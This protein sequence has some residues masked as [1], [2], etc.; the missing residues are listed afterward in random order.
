MGFCGFGQLA[1]YVDILLD[2]DALAVLDDL[3]KEADNWGRKYGVV[4]HEIV[5]AFGDVD[6]VASIKTDLAAREG[7]P[8]PEGDH[9]TLRIAKWVNEVARNPHVKS[10]TTRI[11]VHDRAHEQREQNRRAGGR[12][13]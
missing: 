4:V 9:P 7:A 1:A 5:V 13:S 10:T 2:T 6:I 12:M 8:S 11:I 3:N